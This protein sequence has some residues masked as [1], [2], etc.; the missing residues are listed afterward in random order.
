MQEGAKRRL[1]GAVV[2]V[3]LAVIFVPMLF[4]DN[5][6][7]PPDAETL[8]PDEPGFD[9]GFE[10]DTTSPLSEQIA[11][12]A[13][14]ARPVEGEPLGLPM[15]ESPQD[16]DPMIGDAQPGQIGRVETPARVQTPFEP[17]PPAE[18]VAPARAVSQ[19]PAAP[20]KETAATPAPPKK[21]EVA[22]APAPPPP[23]TDG[24]P[25]WVV[26]VASLG[27]SNSANELAGKLKSAGFT[28][29]VE[30]AEVRGKLFYR[31]RVG[32]EVNRDAAERTAA[33]LRQKQKLDTLIQRYP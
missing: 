8:L 27:S 21:R 9:Q 15:P 5:S 16:A 10:A 24:V 31:V 17:L 11:D 12:G 3:A 23:R 13:E 22:A 7:A 26:Q 18:P 29:F 20:K 33:K 2:I 19:R 4:E 25:S 1:V 32:P 6:L 30:R 28:A 14:V